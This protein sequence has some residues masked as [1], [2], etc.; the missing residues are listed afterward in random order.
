M[1]R[2]GKIIVLLMALAS[3]AAPQV[4]FAERA[5]K[6]WCACY[7]TTDG[8]QTCD[9]TIIGDG[10][11]FFD[12]TEAQTHCQTACTTNLPSS[13]VTKVE[14]GTYVAGGGW[15]QVSD[16]CKAVRDGSNA[17]A[18]ASASSSA[19]S[20]AA[21]ACFCNIAGQGATQQASG[22]SDAEACQKLC[23]GTPKSQGYLY[24][25]DSSQ[26]PSANLQCFSKE[27]LCEKDMDGDGINDGTFDSKQ[28]AECPS[29]WHYCYPSDTKK[30][31]LQISIPSPSGGAVTSVYNY[32]EYVNAVYKYLLGFAVTIAIVFVMI[33]GIRYVVGATTGEIGKAKDMIVK[34]I[35]GLILLLF[36][37]AILYT[38]NPELIK[39]KVPKLPMIRQVS[40]LSG[41]DSCDALLNEGYTIDRNSVTE[42]RYGQNICGS[43]AVVTTKP[44]G[45]EVADGTTC[46]FMDCFGRAVEPGG[47]KET[48]KCLSD[49]ATGWCV[50]CNQIYA[51]NDFGI[52]PSVSRCAS[53][54][55]AD[56]YVNASETNPAYDQYNVCGFTHEPTMFTSVAG[57][58]AALTATTAAAIVSGGTLAAGVGAWYTLDVA[59]EAMTGSCV[60]MTIS[61]QKVVACADYNS[62]AWQVT[63]TKTDNELYDLDWPI[64]GD[65]N[66]VD[67]C[68]SDPC[69]VRTVEGKSKETCVYNEGTGDCRATGFVQAE[70]DMTG[71][72]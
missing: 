27:E 45:T 64:L 68:N 19:G 16:D 63:N 34:A 46:M 25:T 47:N 26:F 35:T 41:G 23:V 21:Q 6:W 13:T 24:A 52:T 15:E 72:H 33:G 44:D 60:D 37:Y 31:T 20:S 11:V 8:S 7:L 30:Y 5:S 56:T 50:S 61:C 12:E 65:P 54:D 66:I 70:P 18:S 36:A 4:A 58:T 14:I 59:D 22:T 39:M 51:E 9:E 1:L 3:F 40:L 32:G 43:M 57:A 42:G 48:A 29:G 69:G 2:V 55:P 53:L 38:V 17:S 49:G 28:P 10:S 71:G 62:S 67:V